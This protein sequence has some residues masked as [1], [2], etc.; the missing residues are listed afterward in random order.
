MHAGALL[1]ALRIRGAHGMTRIVSVGP[2]VA[3]I[4]VEP[5]RQLE[6]AETIAV[7]AGGSGFMRQLETL[8]EPAVGQH[9]DLQHLAHLG[10]TL[11][12]SAEVEPGW[13]AVGECLCFGLN[14]DVGVDEGPAADPGTLKTAMFLKARRSIQP[15]SLSGLWAFQIQCLLETPG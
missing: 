11:T 3:P 1:D 7:A 13:P 5:H 8:R 10:V 6:L 14:G 12:Q 15:F 2:F 4:L 9:A